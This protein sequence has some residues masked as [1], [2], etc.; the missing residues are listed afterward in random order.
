MGG[1]VTV[2]INDPQQIRSS[3]GTVFMK[4]TAQERASAARGFETV[5]G[6]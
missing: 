2:S 1:V 3:N 6:G 4:V 5:L